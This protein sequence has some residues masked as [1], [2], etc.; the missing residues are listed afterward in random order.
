MRMSKLEKGGHFKNDP[1]VSSQKRINRYNGGGRLC[2]IYT[3]E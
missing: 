1:V 3:T 2:L